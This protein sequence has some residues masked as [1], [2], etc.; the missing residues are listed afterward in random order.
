M[1]QYRPP[2]MTI[3]HLLVKNF[4]ALHSVSLVAHIDPD[5]IESTRT[6]QYAATVSRS[7]HAFSQV[8][9]NKSP[10]EMGIRPPEL[11]Y[12][13]SFGRGHTIFSGTFDN[14]GVLNF[15]RGNQASNILEFDTVTH[16]LL[17]KVRRP[18]TATE[19]TANEVS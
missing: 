3:D 13:N 14:I 16:D 15:I 4:T 18:P 11:A 2:M 7:D 8:Y 19:V 10:D 1:K 6:F 5:D 12:Y 9:H 17:L